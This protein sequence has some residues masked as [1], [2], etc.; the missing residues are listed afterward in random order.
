MGE[1]KGFYEQKL[2][3]DDSFSRGFNYDLRAPTLKRETPGFL[4][5]SDPVYRSFPDLDDLHNI[6]I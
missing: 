1:K 2:N 4:G 5:F 3:S 6:Y